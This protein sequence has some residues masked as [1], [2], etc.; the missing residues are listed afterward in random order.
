M[1][2][3]LALRELAPGLWSWSRPRRGLPQ[4][5]T[6][7]VLHD[8]VGTIVVDPFVPREG[9]AVLA[10][11]AGLARGDVRILVTTPFHVR[12][13]EL[14]SRRLRERHAVAI[15]GHVHCATR[16]D[17]RSAFHALRGGETLAGG[18]RVYAIGRPPRAELPY[19]LP[20]HG[21]L[22]FGDTVLEVDGEL[23]VWPRL[24]ADAGGERAYATRLRP[25]LDALVRPGVE[26]VLVTHGAPALRD[27]AGALTEALARAPWSRPST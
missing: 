20:A 10:A 26:R 18:I 23:R 21:A 3:V 6:A 11:L 7:Y 4:T 12:G 19:E 8:D 25:T 2:P 16:L 5:M 27:G 22:A 13:A 17:E 24:R 1:P 14:V 15:A 9:E